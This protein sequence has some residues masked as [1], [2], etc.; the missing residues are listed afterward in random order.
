MFPGSPFHIRFSLHLHPFSRSC[1]LYLIENFCPTLSLLSTWALSPILSASLCPSPYLSRDRSFVHFPLLPSPSNTCLF[2]R[3][4]LYSHLEESR[5]SRPG[6][7]SDGRDSWFR[8]GATQTWLEHAFSMGVIVPPRRG[9]SVIG[10]WENPHWDCGLRPSRA[11]LYCNMTWQRS[12]SLFPDK[13]GRRKKY[14]K[15]FFR[16]KL[17]KEAWE[18]ELQWLRERSALLFCRT[19][20]GKKT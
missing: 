12:W 13:G 18:T 4:W 20:S 2:M 11:Q 5:W 17:M 3:H 10:G 9:K 8:V 7:S 19:R 1:L 15:S 14:F 6:P 16:G